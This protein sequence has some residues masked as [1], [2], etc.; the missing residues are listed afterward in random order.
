MIVNV[1]ILISTSTHS[2]VSF[3]L[4]FMSVFS[5]Y[6]IQYLMSFNYNSEIF[7]SFEMNFSSKDFY[8]ST[9]ILVLVSLLFDIGI[10]RLFLLYGIIADPLKITAE[11]YEKK[12]VL[13]E[14]ILIDKEINNRCNF[15]IFYT[16]VTGS[17]FS[18][19]NGQSPQIHKDLLEIL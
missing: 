10:N 9:I 6:F 1:K 7:N 13:L 2:I 14:N 4:F 11:Q 16:L 3:I 5:Y 15:I 19:D 12:D 17:A 8:L 18:Q